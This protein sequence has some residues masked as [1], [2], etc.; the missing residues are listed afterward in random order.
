V[1]VL[2][3]PYEDFSQ[4]AP[5]ELRNKAEIAYRNR[6]YPLVAQLLGELA[7]RGSEQLYNHVSK[8]RHGEALWKS[9]ERGDMTANERAAGIECAIDLLKEAEDHRD[10]RYAAR[11]KY[12]L[13][14]AYWHLWKYTEN[15]EDLAKAVSKAQEAANLVFEPQYISWYE[16]IRQENSHKP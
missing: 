4:A 7:E 15:D 9:S 1:V 6:N 5:I 8:L 2:P 11:A 13:S 12:Q 3:A 14:K 16:R 10:V